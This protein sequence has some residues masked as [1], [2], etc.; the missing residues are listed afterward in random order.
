MHPA[1]LKARMDDVRACGER[2]AS[3]SAREDRSAILGALADLG[4]PENSYVRDPSSPRRALYLHRTADDRH[5]L[6]SAPWRLA[7]C[8]PSGMAPEDVRRVGRELVRGLLYILSGFTACLALLFGSLAARTLVPSPPPESLTPAAYFQA[9]P[10]ILGC[11]AALFAFAA[12]GHLIAFL[13]PRR[14]LVE[15]AESQTAFADLIDRGDR[16]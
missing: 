11:V 4:L 5:E 1:Y 12:V 9:A 10:A 8:A 15:E 14:A 3:T 13:F 7:R 6:A 16:T 2:G